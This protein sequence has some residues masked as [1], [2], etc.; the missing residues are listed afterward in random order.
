VEIDYANAHFNGTITAGNMIS[1][2]QYGG[3]GGAP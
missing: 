3:D 2:E 1:Q